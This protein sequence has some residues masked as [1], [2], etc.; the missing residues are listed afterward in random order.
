[1][2]IIVIDKSAKNGLSFND[3]D[4][5]TT[6][7]CGSSAMV[8]CSPMRAFNFNTNEMVQIRHDPPVVAVGAKL[9]LYAIEQPK[10]KGTEED[11]EIMEEDDDFSL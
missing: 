9:T 8:K 10:K 1:M 2:G 11:F 4:S 6:F 7:K 3:L 5:G